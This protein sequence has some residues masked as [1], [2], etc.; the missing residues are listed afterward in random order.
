MSK[1]EEGSAAPLLAPDP[2]RRVREVD[3]SDFA[4]AAYR[5]SVHCVGVSRN[6]QSRDVCSR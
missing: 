1:S 4:D 5:R 3:Q 2:Q 6:N